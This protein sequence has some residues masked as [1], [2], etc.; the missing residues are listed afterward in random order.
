MVAESVK[1]VI[2]PVFVGEESPCMCL[3]EPCEAV[4]G[5]VILAGGVELFGELHGYSSPVGGD[6]RTSFTSAPTQSFGA[7]T[8]A[9]P[10]PNGLTSR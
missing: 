1:M 3:D 7:V 6:V 2:V 5:V 9:P 8:C 10:L 4:T